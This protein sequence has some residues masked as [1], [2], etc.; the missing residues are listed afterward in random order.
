M[1]PITI[2]FILLFGVLVFC[3]IVCSIVSAMILTEC[4]SSGY[5][6][7]GVSGKPCAPKGYSGRVEGAKLVDIEYPN[8]K[9][10]PDPKPL[11]KRIITEGK[12]IKGGINR[13]EPTE[14][15]NSTPP[16]VKGLRK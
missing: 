13:Q 9:R 4:R 2:G 16:G 7:N 3:A 12:M 10:P 8:S 1:N 14:R 5:Q 6:P 15:P 11:G